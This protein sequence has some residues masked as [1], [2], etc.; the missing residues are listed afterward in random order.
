MRIFFLIL[1]FFCSPSFCQIWDPVV[2]ST[3]DTQYYLDRTSIRPNG[4]L[5][6]YSQMSNYPNGYKYNDKVIYSIV[7]SRLTD[8][9][10]N[11]FKTVG[12][13]GYSEFNGKGDIFV[14]SSNLD[15][16]WVLIN[17]D[18]VSGEI[19]KEVCR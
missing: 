4:S 1:L 8:C 11:K 2:G 14:V 10:G 7:Q 5:I 18:K 17:M 3:S 13:I 16:E 19:Q 12:M 15:R 6:S 9:V